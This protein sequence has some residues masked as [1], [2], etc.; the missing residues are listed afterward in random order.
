MLSWEISTTWWDH[1]QEL[2]KFRLIDEYGRKEICGIYQRDI[3]NFFGTEDTPEDAE[4][5]LENNQDHLVS[6]ASMLI[7]NDLADDNGIYRVSY[8]QLL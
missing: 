8:D 6:V 5:N 2:L 1:H 7:E 4:Q 3:N